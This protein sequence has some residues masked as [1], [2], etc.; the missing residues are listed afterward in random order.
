MSGTHSAKDGDAAPRADALGT[1]LH[2]HAGSEGS[3]GIIRP[4]MASATKVKRE[5]I[6][7]EIN[8]LQAAGYGLSAKWNTKQADLQLQLARDRVDRGMQTI[9]QLL[10]EDDIE[11]DAPLSY[12]HGQSSFLRVDPCFR[13]HAQ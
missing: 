13:A 1:Q 6:V 8:E 7:A 11:D 9:L 2:E 10:S 5:Q 4:I 3:V 12:L